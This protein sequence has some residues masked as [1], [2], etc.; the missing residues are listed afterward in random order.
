MG[1]KQ[2][3]RELFDGDVPVIEPGTEQKYARVLGPRG[4]H[5]HEVE[6]ADGTK[7]LVTLQPKFRNSVWVKRGKCLWT[8]LM[9]CG[10]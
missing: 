8:L 9:E 1:R 3:P 4:N 10:F 5:Q 6:F 7:T 2:A